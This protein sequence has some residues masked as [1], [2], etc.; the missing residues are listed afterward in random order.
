MQLR[1]EQDFGSV[2]PDAIVGAYQ[3]PELYTE[4]TDLPFVGSP[5]LDSVARD[6]DARRT[7][8]ASRWKVQLELPAVALAFVDPDRLVFV[9]EA[10]LHDDGS[11]TFRIVPD[12]YAKLLRASGETTVSA[13]SGTTVRTT[14]GNLK[15]DLGWKG[16]LFE[17]QVEQAIVDGLTKALRAQVPQI[18][19]TLS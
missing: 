6:E 7:H 19:R 8:V 11:G 5:T 9:E 3:S 18:L 2:D 12:H 13:S 15:V 16:K 17:S 1:V 4:L 14:T 10:E